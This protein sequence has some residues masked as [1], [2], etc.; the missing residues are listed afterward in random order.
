MMP[1][2][3]RRFRL[4]LVANVY[5][6]S[7]TRW[8]IGSYQ[9]VTGVR[10]NK[11]HFCH[12]NFILSLYIVAGIL[13]YYKSIFLP[14]PV[15]WCIFW[16]ISSYLSLTTCIVCVLLYPVSSLLAYFFLAVYPLR[17]NSPHQQSPC[18][19]P[20]RSGRYAGLI[21]PRQKSVSLVRFLK[22]VVWIRA[23]YAL[24]QP[25]HFK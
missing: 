20:N 11:G 16:R 7:R 22:H 14:E 17:P 6:R 4:A 9:C 25:A 15:T 12:T 5:V 23:C 8:S 24:A 19:L 2:K 3:V 21:A 10:Q 1:A 18:R 13:F